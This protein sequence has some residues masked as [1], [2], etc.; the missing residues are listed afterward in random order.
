MQ[1]DG[2]VVSNA[3]HYLSIDS[4]PVSCTRGSL[5]QVISSYKSHLRSA[6]SSEDNI[7]IWDPFLCLNINCPPGSYDANVEPAKDDVLFTNSESFLEIVESFFNKIYGKVQPAPSKPPTK[8]VSRLQ[9]HG[10]E[11]M[12]ARKEAPVDSVPVTISP[13]VG[14]ALP[15]PLSTPELSTHAQPLSNALKTSAIDSSPVVRPRQDGGESSKAMRCANT[16]HSATQEALRGAL[17]SLMPSHVPSS[18]ILTEGIG[19]E[20][21]ENAIC[22]EAKAGWKGSMYAVDEEEEADLARQQERPRSPM[23]L[24]P[25]GDEHLQDVEVSN[26]WAFAKLNAAMRSS[27]RNQQLHT[28]GRQL[29]DA[30]NSNDPSS[31]DFPQQADLP[32]LRKPSP[33]IDQTRSPPEAAYP[34]P[35]PFPFPLKARGRR[36]AENTGIN[37]SSSAATSDKEHNKRG[38][39]DTWVQKCLD[40]HDELEGSPNMLQGDQGP[41]DLSYSPDFVSARSLPLGGT[42]L[43]EIPDASQ[44]TRRKPLPRKQQQGNI[45]RPFVPPVRDPNHVWFDIGEKP[46]QRRPRERRTKNDHQD[47]AKSPPLIL[48]DDEIEDDEADRSLPPMHPDLAIT[49]DYEARKQAA[50]EAHRKVLRQQAAAASKVS[51]HAPDPLHPQHTTTSSS[52]HKN[53][54]AKA[55]AALH[56]ASTTPSPEETA[57]L[58]PSDPRAYLLRTQHEQAPESRTKGKSRRQKTSLLPL[59][60]VTEENYVGDLTFLIQDVNADDVEVDMKESGAWDQYVKR[61]EDG[62]GFGKV[63]TGTMKRWEGRIKEMVREMYAAEEAGGR[64]NVDLDLDLLEKMQVHAVEHV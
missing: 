25:E 9:P 3:G 53:R 20:P 40:G 22:D 39:L 23:D 28:P 38:A 14:S 35:S 16:I 36:K 1:S 32:S 11:I 18:N 49:L 47:T 54:Q 34:T 2:S 29:G 5:Q 26:P 55:I 42:P 56:H 41:P 31:D 33:H 45:D 8:D 43:S 50:S 57:A 10:I 7:K 27:G 4:R 61:G 48:R 15:L 64:A 24:G 17:P 12:L 60:K 59:E 44:R 37:A 19:P 13:M 63:D 52:P 51:T 30:G 58:D 21:S 6:T 46:S 62:K